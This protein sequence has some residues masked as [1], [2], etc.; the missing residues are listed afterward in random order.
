M[1]YAPEVRRRA[2]EILRNQN[3]FQFED[4]LKKV[5]YEE[6]LRETARTKICLDLL[7]N[8]ALCF[9]LINYL[10]IG[11]CVIAYPHEAR[12]HVPLENRKHIVYCRE[13]FSDL[14]ELCEF[15]LQNDEERERVCTASRKFFDDN[16][17]KDNLVSYYL[18]N[19]LD[20]L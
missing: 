6:F 13:D 17:H 16:L 10:A 18:R 9:R 2:V 20:C 4:G 8:G 5:H 7:G 19:C 14:I 15:Y 1:N 3:K 11:T 12:L